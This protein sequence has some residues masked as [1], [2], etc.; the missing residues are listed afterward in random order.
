VHRAF[1]K[2]KVMIGMVLIL[3]LFA[4]VTVQ[5][6]HIEEGGLNLWDVHLFRCYTFTYSYDL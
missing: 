1:R 6:E 4:A 2:L 3:T 5:I